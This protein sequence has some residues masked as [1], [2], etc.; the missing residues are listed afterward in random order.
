MPD[1]FD[2][3]EEFTEHAIPT[4]QKR[5]KKP[6]ATGKIFVPGKRDMKIEYPELSEIEAF[7]TMN[8]KDIRLCWYYSCKS[9]EFNSVDDNN[10]RMQ[11]SLEKAY[12]KSWFSN[13]VAKK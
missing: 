6:V 10:L 9:S 5:E 1:N 3:D 4:T 2:T 7:S 13:G 11:L 8:D 12:G